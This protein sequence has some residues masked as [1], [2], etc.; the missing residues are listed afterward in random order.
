MV[1][2]AD[3]PEKRSSR[4]LRDEARAS[5]VLVESPIQI[6]ALPALAYGLQMLDD[7]G[8]VHDQETRPVSCTGA[9]P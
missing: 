7:G 3:D 9:K 2:M 4:R 8:A 1:E 5:P 6:P